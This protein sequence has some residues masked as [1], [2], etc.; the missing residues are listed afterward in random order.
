MSP[1]PLLDG[2]SGVRKLSLVMLAA[3]ASLMG[4]CAKFP[5]NITT[6]ATRVI[7]R[8]TVRGTIRQ[9]YV[10]IIPIRVSTLLS[11]TDQ[12][13][14]PVVAFPNANG[15][16][17]GHVDYFVVWTPDTQQYT[18]YKF[19]DS[20]LTL[21]T[22]I[23]VPINTVDVTPG[24]STTIGF[25]LSLQQILGSATSWDQLQ[26]IQANFLTMNYRLTAGASASGRIIDCLGNTNLQSDLNEPVT[27]PLATS[28]TYDNARFNEIEPAT[29]DCPDPDLDISD[30]SIEVQRQ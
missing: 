14:I 25:E 21:Y 20:S 5:A 7:F 17:D 3:A 26:S 8:M 23:G 18:L 6:D 29:S 28:G 9:D 2:R 30:W 19:D 4:G 1:N 24:S 22:A 16:V 11:P 12:G 10:Y 13:P 15:F 27:I